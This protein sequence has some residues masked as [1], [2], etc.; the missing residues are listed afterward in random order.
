MGFCG[1]HENERY[2]NGQS[3]KEG[4]INK[5]GG[6]KGAKNWKKRWFALQGPMLTYYVKPEDNP[7]K[8]KG[9]IN[10]S[11]SYIVESSATKRV[12]AFQIVSLLQEAAA[13][14]ACNECKKNNNTKI[15][16]SWESDAQAQVCKL[17]QKKFS[18]YFRKHH[19]RLCG[20][21][22]CGPCSQHVVPMA[23]ARTFY[24][25]PESEESR[26]AWLSAMKKNVT[27]FN[28]DDVILKSGYLSTLTDAE[29]GKWEAVFW[30]LR[31]GRLSYYDSLRDHFPPETPLGV[32]DLCTSTM[33]ASA[34]PEHPMAIQIITSSGK[35]YHIEII[36]PN[37][38]TGEAKSPRYGTLDKALNREMPAL[39]DGD[40]T[41]EEWQEAIALAM[42]N[43]V[44]GVPLYL[45]A[46]RSDPNGL[47]PLPILVATEWLNKRGFR[48]E[49]LYRIPGS[50]DAVGK[51]VAS[52]DRGEK[53]TIPDLFYPG[54]LASLVV[55]FLKRMPESL[56]TDSHS[57][58][59]EKLSADT[60]K[61]TATRVG[62]MKKLLALIPP[63]N[64]ATIRLLIFHLRNVSLY[65]EENQMTAAKLSMCVY[66][67][68]A[69]TVGFLIENC[70]EVIENCRRPFLSF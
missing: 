52:F 39:G 7:H 56:F 48:E 67:Q 40:D 60:S 28:S 4:W 32:I 10:L 1:E 31:N 61:D 25:E 66:T 53:V 8:P 18:L 58:V 15:C 69:Q 5:K 33:E 27:G 68:M 35:T 62:M 54:N 16:T 57:E 46:E 30:V 14:R 70:D 36:P 41:I 3:D 22:V 64:A 19:C 45:A 37:D 55:Q 50:K 34:Y 51:L 12:L 38:E 63:C 44:F 43:K 21:V 17:C 20:S 2:A 26:A 42:P 24:L 59:F 49:G 23:C 29:K 13:Q 6:V 11:Q 47:V 9:T 65:A